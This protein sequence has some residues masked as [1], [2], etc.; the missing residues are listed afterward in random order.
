MGLDD[1]TDAQLAQM[2][3]ED[4][5]RLR[6]LFPDKAS[7]NRLAPFD[8][9]SDVLGQ[10]KSFGP[11]A[12][13]YG[14]GSPIFELLKLLSPTN[15]GSRS[16]PS[17]A[18]AMSGISAFGKG[19]YDWNRSKVTNKVRPPAG[20]AW[21]QGV[22]SLSPTEEKQRAFIAKLRAAPREQQLQFLGEQFSQGIP[23]TEVRFQSE[24]PESQS[25]VLD[26]MRYQRW[27]AEE[28]NRRPL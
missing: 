4:I 11:Q 22:E 13:I 14:L 7:Q 16:D 20:D 24:Q 27:K 8:R 17:L 26:M 21:G 1:Y 9:S 2:S 15:M 5:R 10:M 3:F 28:M 12:G 19:L 6:E 23:D 25:S 18:N